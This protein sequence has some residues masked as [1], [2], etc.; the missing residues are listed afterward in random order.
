MFITKQQKK[1]SVML[2]RDITT[3]VFIESTKNR[4]TV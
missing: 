4:D 1:T 3:N 2:R